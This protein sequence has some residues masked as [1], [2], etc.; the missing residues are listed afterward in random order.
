MENHGQALKKP[1]K[2][3]A[4]ISFRLPNKLDVVCEADVLL[5][6]LT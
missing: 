1:M 2:M 3:K 6:E 4:G 5:R